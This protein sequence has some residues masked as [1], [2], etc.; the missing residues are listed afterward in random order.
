VTGMVISPPLEST[1]YSSWATD[2]AGVSCLPHDTKK[3]VKAKITMAYIFIIIVLIKELF[4]TI[5]KCEY[6]QNLAFNY[7]LSM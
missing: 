7:G 3:D 5:P 2:M 6:I 4:R 1:K